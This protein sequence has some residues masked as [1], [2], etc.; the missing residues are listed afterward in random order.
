MA[1]VDRVADMVAPLIDPLG[2]K[3]YDVEV[4]GGVLRITVEAIDGPLELDHVAKATRAISAEFDENDPMPGAYTLEVSSPGLERKLRTPEHYVGAIDEEV[5]VKLGSHIPDADRRH[6]G[7][8]A[9][10]DDSGIVLITDEGER[11]T[12]AFDDITKASTVFEWG[13]AP[14]PGS[15][16]AKAAKTK[17]ERRATAQ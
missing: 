10:V 8:L 17:S 15:K 12:L 1:I 2:L 5:S 16:E 3:L 7:Q 4:N 13:P 11:R 9:E 14:K 6:K